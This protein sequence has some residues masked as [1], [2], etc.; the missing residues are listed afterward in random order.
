MRLPG[1][2]YSD[3]GGE[4]SSAL[5]ICNTKCNLPVGGNSSTKDDE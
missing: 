5:L 1:M 2:T 4:E 3:H